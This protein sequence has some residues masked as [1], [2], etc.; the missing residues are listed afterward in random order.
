MKISFNG[1]RS[2]KKEI[3][4]EQTTTP[5]EDIN[6]LNKILNY[7]DSDVLEIRNNKNNENNIV[8][9]KI[10]EFK[11]GTKIVDYSKNK[12]FGDSITLKT[13]EAQGSDGDASTVMI[14]EKFDYNLSQMNI[15]TDE[16]KGLFGNVIAHITSLK[17][18][19]NNSYN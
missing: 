8:D 18:Q 17:E 2:Y 6:Q 13:F 14:K 19:W 7:K 12:L 15:K 11:D 5:Q 3:Y 9:S 1:T 10:I 4:I 16:A